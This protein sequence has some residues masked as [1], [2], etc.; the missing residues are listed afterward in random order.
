MAGFCPLLISKLPL[1]DYVFFAS[2]SSSSSSLRA[3]VQKA[4]AAG[5]VRHHFLWPAQTKRHEAGLRRDS[6]TFKRTGS[7][8]PLSNLGCTPNSYKTM[9]SESSFPLPSFER[10]RH[11]KTLQ[12][13]K[14]KA[15][16][17]FRETNERAEA[18]VG[19]KASGVAGTRRWERRRSLMQIVMHR[20]ISTK[21]QRNKALFGRAW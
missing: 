3:Y 1:R 10:R 16:N 14:K 20:G 5:A 15:E 4:S 6:S 9:P 17:E 18:G 12:N 13:E 8:R 11:R 19:V 2:F 7:W 21:Q